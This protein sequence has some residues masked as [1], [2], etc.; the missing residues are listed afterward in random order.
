MGLL[1]IFCH[2]QKVRP[3]A[4][5]ESYHK[6]AVWQTPKEG[7]EA[8]CELES[9]CK[10]DSVIGSHLSGTRVT[11]R[12]WQPTRRLSPEGKR[13]GHSPVHWTFP[14]AWPCS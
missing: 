1:V 5:E 9:V 4:Q 8:V 7:A 13:T 14:P 10:P 6:T 2:E 12:L 11:S 3:Q